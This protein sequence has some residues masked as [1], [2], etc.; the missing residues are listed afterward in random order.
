MFVDRLRSDL[1]NKLINA[2]PTLQ[3]IYSYARPRGI[4]LSARVSIYVIIF[5]N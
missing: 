2:R 3:P 5:L 4:C 1:L